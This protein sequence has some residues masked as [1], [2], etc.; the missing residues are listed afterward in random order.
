MSKSGTFRTEI[1]VRI[2]VE[3]SISPAEPDVGCF[4]ESI[5]IEEIRVNGYA[6]GHLFSNDEL[7]GIKEMIFT[8]H[9]DAEDQHADYIHDCRKDEG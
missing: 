6:E 5:E 3:Y 4:S 7:E 2:E 9:N 8:E 1:E